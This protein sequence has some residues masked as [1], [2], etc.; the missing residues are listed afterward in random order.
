M[1]L[2]EKLGRHHMEIL[3]FK[4]LGF[5]RLFFFFFVLF[6]VE[7]ALQYLRFKYI[8]VINIY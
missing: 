1:D 5:V 3:K 2:E 4:V 8:N 6:L 7:S